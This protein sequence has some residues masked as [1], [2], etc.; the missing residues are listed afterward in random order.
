MKNLPRSTFLR[1]LPPV[2]ALTAL[3]PLWGQNSNEGEEELVELNPF[4]VETNSNVGYQATHTLGGTRIRTQLED[5]GSSIQ[6][7]TADF[8]EDTGATD[9]QSLL[10]Y[11]TNTEVG[12]ID[13]NFGGAGNGPAVYQTFGN[14][15]NTTRVRGLA[16][17]DNTRN[18]FLTDVPW[19]SY[20]VE[21][22]EIQRGPNAILFG[23]GSPAGIINTGLISPQYKDGYKV[24]V[25][26]D[27]D[28]S[29]R[30]NFDLNKV[31]LKDEL[32]IR[33]AGLMNHENYR[34]K[35]AYKDDERIWAGIKYEPSWLRTKSTRT[36]LNFYYEDGEIEA[37]Q[38][39]TITPIDR[40]SAWF[41]PV[42]SVPGNL[43]SPF[44]PEGGLGQ[45]FFTPTQLQNNRIPPT[46]NAG[47]TRSNYEDG[48][49]NPY[50]IPALGNFG[51]VFGGPAG[52]VPDAT[53]GAV[54]GGQV[55]QFREGNGLGPDGNVDGNI[56]GNYYAVPGGVDT[57]NEFARKAGLPFA[58]FGQY[59]QST[60]TDR[61]IFDFYNRLLDGPNKAEGQEFDN[62]NVSLQQFFFQNRLGFEIA[63]DVQNYFL[64]STRLLVDDRQA[65]MVDINETYTDGTPNPNVG[66]PFVSDS[67][68]FGN[69]SVDRE[70]EANRLTVFAQHDFEDY[71]DNFWT[72]LAG[73]QQLTFLLSSE[74]AT[75]RT[76][77]WQQWGMG[78]DFRDFIGVPSVIDNFNAFSPVVYLGPSVLGR[79]SASGLGLTG[80]TSRVVIPDQVSI[81]IFDD[82]WNAPGVDP[83]AYYLHP[84]GYGS[85]QS[86]NPANYVGWTDRS[87]SIDQVT[88]DDPTALARNGNL[89]RDEIDSEA[90]VLQNF[91]LEG[92]VVGTFGWRRD[93]AKASL[94]NA[95][96]DPV[97]NRA[98]IED[99]SL[100]NR[101]PSE[102]EAE[103]RSYSAVVHLNRLPWIEDRLPLNVSLYYNESRNFQPSAGRID[104]FGRPL[105]PPS[106][107]TTERSI[108]LQTKGGRLSLFITRYHT[109]LTNATGDPIEGQWFLGAAQAWGENWKNI[110]A[111]DSVAGNSVPARTIFNTY[112][113]LEGQTQA[114]ADAFEASVVAGWESHVANLRALSEELTGRSD[115]FDQ[116]FQI[117]RSSLG[118]NSISASDPGGLTFT[119]DTVSKGWEFELTARPNDNWDISFNAAQVEAVRRNIGGEALTRYVELVN[120]DFNNTP[121]GDLRIYGGWVSAPTI[122]SLWN[123]L[124]NGNYALARLLEDTPVPEIREWRFNVVTNYH[125]T[126]GRFR[127]INLGGGY[128]WQD[129]VVIGFKPEY[130]DAA[131][132]TVTYDLNRPYLGPS[133]GNLDLW[134]GYYRRLGERIDWHIQLNV[135]NVFA[136]GDLIPINT[137]P[138]GTPGAWRLGAQRMWTLTNTFKF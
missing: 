124:F 44:N 88:P 102:F 111:L 11:T 46:P 39:R 81:R 106:G 60:I 137:Q 90:F 138:D 103:T 1:S 50:F 54:A 134:V 113:P 76:L 70:R 123:S 31:I 58:E 120:D 92:A 115:A 38:P 28:S 75:S 79:D 30:A 109:A 99:L 15:S 118:Y 26:T 10:Q 126:E 37:N 77:N 13:G 20:I 136:D 16:A 27:S 64:F 34:Q 110:F 52:F 135:R 83:G 25:G 8:L 87:F 7:I 47:Q 55:L 68:Q 23:F 56:G 95:V 17:A 65:L 42:R 63:R 57:F 96:V 41:R 112:A 43:A 91:F 18:Y 14:P 19:D 131:Q 9:N 108:L 12:G 33:V 98:R 82:T 97:T 89:S 6:V 78:Q 133:E 119:Q 93:T 85:T 94:D 122:G 53:T 45:E 73:R 128:R 67:S 51:F 101:T 3:V 125:F 36:V 2:L 35:P 4:V 100:A 114:D 132:T 80:L 24:Q 29:F 116:T 129:D 117:D 107:K 121:A 69:Y 127:G 71:A 59:K 62:Y 49:P 22:V 105:D 32:A 130:A 66:R 72:R 74:K 21:R 40:I 84:G 48:T 61:S 104:L 5:I 86:E